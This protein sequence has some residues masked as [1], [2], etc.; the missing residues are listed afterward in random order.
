M[1]FS[2]WRR[3]LEPRAIFPVQLPLACYAGPPSAR[4]EIGMLKWALFF[5]ILSIIA[6]V[7]GFTGISAAAAGIA[8]VLFFIFIVIFVVLLILALVVGRAIL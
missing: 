8:K 1:T 7:F 6:G 3:V 5:L 2:I 4:E